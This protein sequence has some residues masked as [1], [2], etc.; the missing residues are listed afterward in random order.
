M[1]GSP[2]PGRRGP[3]LRSVVRAG[4]GWSRRQ[5]DSGWCVFTCRHFQRKD[6][7][8]CISRHKCMRP[9]AFYCAI[10]AQCRCAVPLCC[11]CYGRVLQIIYLV[12]QIIIVQHLRADNR[13]DLPL[14]RTPSLIITLALV[15]YTYRPLC[16]C[17]AFPSGSSPK[18]P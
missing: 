16:E 10:I 15:N 3:Q 18:G 4:A 13:K 7:A 2:R 5:A 9:I 14:L 17:E 11:N 12:S 8:W 6:P 1:R